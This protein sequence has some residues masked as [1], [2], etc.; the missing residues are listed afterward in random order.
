MN[1]HDLPGPN[2]CAS[3][4]K[5]FVSAASPLGLCFLLAAPRAD[6]VQVLTQHND[7]SRTGANLEEVLL[8]PA[9]VNS[10]RFGKLFTRTVDGSIYA[11]PLYIPQLTISNKTQNVVIVATEHNTV[12]SFDADDPAASNALWQVNLGTSVPQ[13]E[14]NN[15][16]DLPP[17]IGITGTPAIDPAGGTIYVDAKTKVATGSTTNYFHSLHALDL[18]TGHEKFGS[19]VVIQG[20]TFDARHNHNRPGLALLNNV[21]YLG[22]GSHCDWTPY[23]GWLFGY[24][25]TNLQQVAIFNTTSNGSQGAIW[26]CGM[27]P[28]VDTNGN[29]YVV[30]GNGTFDANTGGSDYGQSFLKFSTSNGL[31]LVDWF[32]P[33]N[34][35]SLSSSD[36]D[37]GTGGAVLLPGSQLLAGLDKAGTLFVLN[38]TNLGH[39]SNNGSSDTNIVQEFAATPGTD[40]I[41][42]CPVYWNGPTNQYL[43]IACGNGQLKSFRFTGTSIQTTPLATGSVTE[44]DRAGGLSLSANGNTNGIVWVVD[45]ANGGT[46]RAYNPPSIPTEL[47]DSQM[48]SARDALGAYV[49]FCAPTIANGKVYMATAAKLLVVYGLFAV[50]SFSVSALP[51][52]QTVNEG[53]LAMSYTVTVTFNNLFANA[54]S[55]SVSG[56]PAGASADFTQGSFTSSG[57]STLSVT[58]SNATPQGSYPLTISGVAGTLTN[59]TTV[60]LVVSGPPAPFIRTVALSGTNLVLSGTNG[61]AGGSYSLLASTNLVLP[62]TNWTPVGTGAFDAGGNFALTNGL[63]PGLPQLF[64]RLQVP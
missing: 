60:T 43:F 37:I 7:N 20:S 25:A 35:V 52:S 13:S 36:R 42:Q 50:P 49:K 11:Q 9:N 41:G 32:A 51:V 48:N 10:S 4:T 57:N 47:W 59:S 63:G 21:V 30:T 16:G 18:Y 45:N 55:L 15:C 28:A 54:V 1:I 26:S 24:N 6:G 5:F 44:N 17:E 56:L 2:F 62:L 22:F 27:A 34:A 40:T 46:L 39:F 29:L 8:A 33:W 12:Y 19:P 23:H 64:F 31:K 3:C 38:Q 61:P 53:G 58:A 14:V